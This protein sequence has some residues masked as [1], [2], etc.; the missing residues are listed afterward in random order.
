MVVGGLTG[1]SFIVL[2][3]YLYKRDGIK[4]RHVH[5]DTA[6]KIIVL[7]LVG[8]CV[9]LGDNTIVFW[10]SRTTKHSLRTLIQVDFVLFNDALSLLYFDAIL[11][12]SASRFYQT[13]GDPFWQDRY[14]A[15]GSV[16]DATIAHSKS[17][18]QTLDDLRIY[19]V[20]RHFNIS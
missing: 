9:A 18:A 8:V 2:D 11:T 14:N 3:F 20:T 19:D 16:N 10:I 4:I 7:A 1:L 6:K 13:G 12:G 15:I 17:L 5:P